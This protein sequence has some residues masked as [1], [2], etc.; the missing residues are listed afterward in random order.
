LQF[1]IAGGGTV[2]S[3]MA[4]FLSHRGEKVTLI[5]SDAD[6][7]EWV[8]KHSDAVVYRGN[9][10]DPAILSQA[11]VSRADCLIV[12]LANDQIGRE[13]VRLAKSQFAVPKVIAVAKDSQ[14]KERMQK[15]GAE[16][17]ICSEDAVLDEIKELLQA[18]SRRTLFSE[19]EGRYRIEQVTVRATSAMLGKDASNLGNALA[20]VAGVVKGG[21]LLFPKAKMVLQLGDEVIVIGKESA[22]D[23][24]CS[25]IEE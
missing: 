14:G 11:E 7:C 8:S 24:V 13:L 1:L 25:Q 2:G 6:R 9:A 12:A 22:V 23:R 18:K 16:F 5:D 19:R 10:L 17:A 21:N 15:L 3:R 4:V 20:Q